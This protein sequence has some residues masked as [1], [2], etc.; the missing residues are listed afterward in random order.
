MSTPDRAA[1]VSKPDSSVPDFSRNS[2]LFSRFARNASNATG[3]P[4]AFILAAGIVAAWALSGPVFG[5]SATWQLVINTGT[6]IVTFLMVFLV[7]NTQNRDAQ[8]MQTKLNELIR[9]LEGADNSLLDL[10]ESDQ[11][12]LDRTQAAYKSIAQ[13]ERQ[14][15]P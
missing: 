8:A 7:Q 11:D 4:L 12:E 6:T 10:E 5:F 13:S 9:A 3:Q 2:S 1:M 15:Q 14:L